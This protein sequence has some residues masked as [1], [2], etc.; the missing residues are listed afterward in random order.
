MKKLLFAAVALVSLAG[1]NAKTVDECVNLTPYFDFN[2]Q[3]EPIRFSAGVPGGTFNMPLNWYNDNVMVD[4]SAIDASH[5]ILSLLGGP[6]NGS[7]EAVRAEVNQ[8]VHLINLGGTAGTVWALDYK[9]SDFRTACGY[10]ARMEDRQ[11]TQNVNNFVME[12]IPSHESFAGYEGKELRCRIEF[13]AYRKAGSAKANTE[14][15]KAV[16]MNFN[17]SVI[18]K[19]TSSQ[20]IKTESFLNEANEF[21]AT[22]WA[23]YD[24]PFTASE[25]T[26]YLQYLKIEMSSGTLLDATILIRG[27]KFYDP[28]NVSDI[29][30]SVVTYKTYTAG[31]I[32][33]VPLPEDE[34]KLYMTQEEFMDNMT[35][36]FP[37]PV[38]HN[39]FY[40]I[41]HDP[42]CGHPSHNVRSAASVS[43][44][45]SLVEGDTYVYH[46]PAAGHAEILTL[47]S[48]DKSTGDRVEITHTFASNAVTGVETVG[49]DNDGTTAELYNLEGVRVDASTAAPGIYIERRG[50]LARKV[51]R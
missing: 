14:F 3:T 11:S 31:A 46:A 15:F 18:S 42:A 19:H 1:V 5:G 4:G 32:I 29:P 43:E 10:E 41:E 39:L 6:H 2:R 51:A 17:N 16:M 49:I 26:K 28:E 30:E 22:K 25:N 47:M 24:F 27:I 44:A 8:S 33:P 12:F 21:D 45:Y 34:H 23:V 40:K 37:V 7:S 36:S 20:G 13:C 38:N 9:G 50:G 48:E 35:V